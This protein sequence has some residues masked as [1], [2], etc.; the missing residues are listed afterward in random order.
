MV[1]T[2]VRRRRT[3]AL[4]VAVGLAAVVAGPMSQALGGGGQ[5]MRT[6]ASRRIVVARGETL[7]SIARRWFPGE[8]PRLVIDRIER[9]NRVA[10][11]GIAPGEVLAVPGP[12]AG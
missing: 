4:V 2:R 6:V 9:A 8:D 12:P 7:W 11:G 5:G 10:S 3:G 1:R